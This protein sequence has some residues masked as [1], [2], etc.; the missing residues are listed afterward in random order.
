ML[1]KVFSLR[2][3]MLYRH[4]TNLVILS[5]TCCLPVDLRNQNLG[6]RLK[7]CH[8]GLVAA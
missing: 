4:S 2:Q 3:V 7:L 1:K 5:L 8:Q 6:L